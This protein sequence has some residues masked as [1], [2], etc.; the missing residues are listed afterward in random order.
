MANFTGSTRT[1]V[2]L[3]L[4]A[5]GTWITRFNSDSKVYSS[6]FSGAGSTSVK[7]NSG[8]YAGM[9]YSGRLTI[10]PYSLMIL[11]QQ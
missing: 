3:G 2:R 6:T 9:P 1:G 11:S 5:S 8:A 7:A 4:P 10:G